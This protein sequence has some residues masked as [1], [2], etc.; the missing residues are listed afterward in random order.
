MRIWIDLANSPQVPFFLPLHAA[1][2]GQDHEVFV[3]LRNYAETV[4]LAQ[5]F[6]IGGEPIGKHGG[7]GRLAKLPNL[8]ARSLQLAGYARS[9]RPEIAVCHNSPTHVVAGRLIGARVINIMDFE[10]QPSNHLT[11]RIA[12]KVIVP[13]SFPDADLKR[14]GARPARV[15][16]YD[17]FKEQTY[18]SSFEPDDSF[19]EDFIDACGLDP[20]WDLDKT[21]LV[22]IRTPPTQAAYHAFENP[23]FD[24][25]L[26]AAN[27]NPALTVIALPRNP[28]QQEGIRKGYPN[29]HIPKRPVD[30]RNLL[31]FSDLVISGGGTMNREAA[32]LGTPAYTI[33]AGRLPAVDQSLIDLGRMRRITRIEE[34][35]AIAFQKKEPREV[36][37]NPDLCEEL[38]REMLT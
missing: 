19:L 36:L 26:T 8:A 21:T 24:R 31:F 20:S 37:R 16:K 33:F 34:L 23:L 28:H 4:P 6:G 15:Y 10:G 29:L 5:K 1:L 30:G 35:D 3:T 2:L 14:L 22:T 12:H 9:R 38:V 27:V 7:S 11:F 13:A 25:L 17:G 32:I 18:L